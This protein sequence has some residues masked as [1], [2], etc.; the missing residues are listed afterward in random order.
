MKRFMCA[1]MVSVISTCGYAAEFSRADVCKAVISVEMGR[2]T[3]TMKSLQEG[4]FPVISY[5]REDD[6]QEFTYRCKFVGFQVYWSGYFDSEGQWGRWRD[7][8][9]FDPQ[10]RYRLEFGTLVIIHSELGEKTF[11]PSDF[12][13]LK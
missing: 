8:L 11:Y 1:F 4:N 9:E 7:N 2:E 3:K 12:K 5:V 6:L 13:V 10:Y